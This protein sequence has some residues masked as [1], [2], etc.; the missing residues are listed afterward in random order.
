MTNCSLLISKEV[1]S[2]KI[3]FLIDK[4]KS[5]ENILLNQAIPYVAHSEDMEVIIRKQ[6]QVLLPNQML[7]FNGYETRQLLNKALNERNPS[8]S[9][10][11]L[12]GNHPILTSF[13]CE[14]LWLS[15]EK[16]VK[17]FQENLIWVLQ[18]EKF[19]FDKSK[20]ERIS[21][22]ISEIILQNKQ[23]YQLWESLTQRYEGEV[24]STIV[25]N[26][27]IELAKQSKSKFLAGIVPIVDSK[28]P[29]STS[30]C[31]RTNI[32]YSNFI[33]I[34]QEMGDSPPRYLYALPI[35]SSVIT[36]EW[37]DQLREIVL[38]AKVAA[39][40]TKFDGIF[41]A[42]RG[43]KDISEEPGRVNTLT[44]L[45]KSL[46]MIAYEQLLPIWWSR[47]EFIGMNVLDNGGNFFSYN[48]NLK[49][50]DVYTKF[51]SR[52]LKPVDLM[53]RTG[54]FFHFEKRQLL[55]YND[56]CNS[57]NKFQTLR[58]NSPVDIDSYNGKPVDCRKQLRKPHNIEEMNK[59]VEHWLNHVKD[60]EM[61]P[62]HEY[63][64]GFSEPLYRVWGVQ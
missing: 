24:L 25:I 21:A 8:S 34:Q 14:V 59:M 1:G 28:A 61:N 62:G 22:K 6:N 4:L 2:A 30:L 19:N 16:G 40:S 43:L 41:V 64:Q 10:Q 36:N 31:H 3:G 13:P 58:P 35:N 47:T 53:K 55:D 20:A 27:S 32:A 26:A 54:K 29:N 42:V 38:N 44:K 7:E 12:S 52:N 60:G 37:S 48:L 50:E 57:R 56:V 23:K 49:M 51:I 9:Y 46:N 5:F 39:E 63:L 15:H 33:Q 17:N 45:M 11:E 18:K